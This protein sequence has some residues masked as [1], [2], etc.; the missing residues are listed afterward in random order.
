MTTHTALDVLKGARQRLA[1]NGWHT[2][3]LAKDKDGNNVLT[4]DPSACSFCALGA[5]HAQ[6]GVPI[7]FDLDEL[8]RGR[9]ARYAAADIL[10]DVVQPLLLERQS[11]DLDEFPLSGVADWN[12]LVAQ[13]KDEV[14]A[15]FDEAIAAATPNDTTEVTA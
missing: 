9:E 6:A 14:L 7:D 15:V 8:E 12:D 10:R 3:T 13:T 4:S 11:D 2:G 5:I 1:D